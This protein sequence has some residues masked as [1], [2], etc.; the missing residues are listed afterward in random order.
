MRAMADHTIVNL[1]DVDDAAGQRGV[2]GLQARF[3][4]SA[5]GL[6]SSGITLF[7]LEPD[8]KVPWGHRHASQEEI[9]LVLRGSATV[10][11][12]DAKAEL[13]EWDAV[14]IP[15]EVA[16][17]FQAGPDGAQVLAF[18]AGPQGDAEMITD[19]W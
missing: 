13:G 18:G 15:P 19:F 5:L 6:Q 1:K 17:S 3:A 9:Y 7:D 16:R 8:F 2:P 11:F 14:R 10:V 4:R 12:E